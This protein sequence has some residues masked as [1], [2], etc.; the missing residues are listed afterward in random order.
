M[1]VAKP[2]CSAGRHGDGRY[3]LPFGFGDGDRVTC[4]RGTASGGPGHRAN[5]RN[6]GVA[7]W[8]CTLL[9]RQ[10]E[11]LVRG[12]P[13]DGHQWDPFWTACVVSAGIAHRGGCREGTPLIFKSAVP[14]CDSA[15]TG[16]IYFQF[17]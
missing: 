3:C 7:L 2:S 4:L 13:P 11:V 5:H 12:P 8:T 6:R 16:G 14:L 9:R 15:P 1:S 17:P 10:K